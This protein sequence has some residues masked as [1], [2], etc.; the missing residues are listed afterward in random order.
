MKTKKILAIFLTV[1]M[2]VS[3]SAVPAFSDEVPEGFSSMEEYYNYLIYGETGST[4]TP[5]L[6]EMRVIGENDLV[7]LYFFEDGMD[8]FAEDKSTGKVFGSQ[9]DKEYI[10]IGNLADSMIS[11]LLT[12]CYADGEDN[13]NEIDLTSAHVEGLAVSTTY[14]ENSVS[15]DLTVQE[16]AI[17]LSVVIT[18]TEDG[19]TVEIPEESIKEEGEHLL[20]SVRLLP[21]FGAA[22]PGE[23]G[24]V[25]YPDGSGA[26]MQITPDRKEQPEFYQLPIY[27]DNS[28]S[29]ETYDQEKEL[30]IKALMLPVFGI[31]HSDG[32]VFAE[33]VQGD[34][35]ADLHI[36]VD[37]LYQ[38]YFEL[39]YRS[40]NTVSYTFG[41]GASGELHKISS[42]RSAGGRIVRYHLLSGEKNTYSDMAMLYRRQLIERGEL[43][44]AENTSGVPLSIEFFMGISKPGILGDSIQCLTDFSDAASI[45]NDLAESGVTGVSYLLKGWCKG[46]YTT[47]P[48]IASAERKLGG[49]S[50]LNHF[51]ETVEQNNGTAYLLADAINAN[52]KSGTFNVQK[53]ALRDAINTT[54]TDK[55]GE[56]YWLNPTIY[57][58][59]AAKKLTTVLKS[60]GAICFG[61]LGSW[62]T[63][64]LGTEHPSSRG[65]IIDS[66][67]QVLQNAISQNETTAAVGGNLY[68]CKIGARLYD[69]P[70]ND[71]GYCQTD[72]T[73]PFWQMIMHG[74]VSYSSLAVNLSYNFKV[75]KLHYVETGSIPH[76]I[77]TENSPNLLHGTSYSG[78]FNS[79][80]RVLK[81]TV[82]SVYREMN[83]RLNSVWGLTIDR[84]EILSDTLVKLTY[85]D[86]SAVYI[87]YGDHEATVDGN[88]IPPTDYLLVKGA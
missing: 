84:H 63:A 17:T 14:G 34:A 8:L 72:Y 7:K 69:I 3:F 1:C 18:L 46:G 64:D 21:A 12:V 79:E 81:E 76:F 44:K 28:L 66:V 77:L 48:T 9:V 82:L 62:L 2:T 24:Y 61:E 55:T 88:I 58:P 83:E 4:E 70:D 36:A 68:V 39:F 85:S 49:G 65:E 71:S 60:G 51:F 5:S 87:N 75:Q 41:S 42:Q 43:P 27:C 38:S 25:F 74:A 33:I 20:V 86:G 11:N 78:I 57:L 47:L 32:G 30:D 52:S 10:D 45:V 26:I 13:L 35:D 29:F 16:T 73:V 50:G 15:L 23:D 37:A 56:R 40:Y 19:F 31:K 53:N 59:N 54:L 67:Q 80:Y 6:S 22:R